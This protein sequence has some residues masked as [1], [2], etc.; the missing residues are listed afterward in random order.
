M[1]LGK[2]NV[3]I[4]IQIKNVQKITELKNSLKALRKE[5]RDIE[6]AT[7]EGSKSQGISS[8][9][10]NENA[11]A[12]DNQSKSLRELNRKQKA[13]IKS[14]GS[15]AK[16]MIKGAA[17]IGI[18][19]GAFRVIVRTVG[20]FVSTFT[21]FEFVMAKVRAVSG[22]TTK[23]FQELTASAEELGRTTFFTATQVGELQLAYSKL[24]FT[25]REINQ[26]SEATIDLATATGT[27]LQRASQVA[28]ASIRGFGLDASETQRVVDVM[29]VSFASS[30]MDIEK[31]STSMTKVAPIAQSAGFSIE[32][33]ASIMSKLT[34]SG[35]EASIAGTSLRNI[36]LKMQDP[37]SKLSQ[38]FG[39]TIHSLDD[40][41]PAMKKF[42]SEGGSM[43]EV[44]E[45]VDIR[46][47]GAFETMLM[48]T[49]TILEYRDSLEAAT[50]EGERMAAM[51]G[52]TLQGSFLKVK[53]AAQ[54]VSISLMKNFSGALK[55]NMV[56][57]SAWLN[58]L[59]QSPSKLADVIFWVKATVRAILSVVVGLKVMRIATVANIAVQKAFSLAIGNSA[60]AL[61]T[62]KKA[63]L[64]FSL[65][66]KTLR[67][68]IISTGIGALVVVLGELAAGF[69]MAQSKE[70]KMAAV[71]NEY[72]QVISEMGNH[73]QALIDIE[74]GADAATEDRIGL[75]GALIEKF[76]DLNT[77]DKERE[78]ILAQ[79]YKLDSEHFADL[80]IGE[81]NLNDL[82]KAR[83]LY[84]AAIEKE[85]E[86]KIKVQQYKKANKEIEG[87]EREAL[88]IRANMEKNNNE[89]IYHRRIKSE[90]EWHQ[91]TSMMFKNR[92]INT[93][94]RWNA[95]HTLELEVI[96]KALKGSNK[97]IENTK[98]AYESRNDV[99]IAEGEAQGK[100]DE[101]EKNMQS[102]ILNIKRRRKEGQTGAEWAR[103][104]A[105]AT[106]RATKSQLHQQFNSLGETEKNGTKGINMLIKIQDIELQ[107][108]IAHLNELKELNSKAETESFS[109]LTAR[110]L[111]REKL[112]D[113]GI[114]GN[115]IS[116]YNRKEELLII[117]NETL[118]NTYDLMG[119]EEKASNIGLQNRLKFKKN[120][121]A[122][123]VLWNEAIKMED[124]SDYKEQQHLLN[125]SLERKEISSSEH[126]EKMIDLSDEYLEKKLLAVQGD[127]KKEMKIY[128]EQDKNNLKRIKLTNKK[129]LEIQKDA[130]KTKNLN[131]ELERASSNMSDIEFMN[132]KLDLEQEALNAK[133]IL[134]KDDAD[135]M[136]D[137][138]NEQL[139][140]DVKVFE[141]Q[142]DM[143]QQAIS[144]MG[145]VGSALTSLAGDNEKL[146][147]V[148]EIGNA[149]T[150]VSNALTT[151]QTL[152]TNLNTLASAKSDGVNIL[153]NITKKAGLFLTKKKIL[154]ETTE[155]GI[156]IADTT[157]TTLGTAAQIANT[158]ATG[159]DTAVTGAGL[160]VKATD[161][162]LSSA[163]GL[164][165][166]GIVAM[167]AMAAMV[168]KVMKMFEHGGV[169]EG[170]GKFANGGMVHGPSHANGGVKFA[171]GGRVNEL[172][173]G[174][175]VINKRSTA[176]FRNQL[177]SMNQ[178]GGGVKFADG[179]LMSSPAFS[180]AQFNANNQNQMMGAMSGQRKVVVVESDIT[181]SQATVNV[182]QANA[183]F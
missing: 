104:E 23:E 69:M 178:A 5:Q 30:A 64:A 143:R 49:D 137:I 141:T 61:G 102:R 48:S 125:V 146:N 88:A 134:Y 98:E 139:A 12:V 59:A 71:T 133:A 81:T 107:L 89:L 144:A 70:E 122:L 13:A 46:Q 129:K 176:M 47:A 109:D 74:E 135:M 43:A 99:I 101:W 1:A 18:L 110:L 91:T 157:A 36:L 31:W 120:E 175:A 148:K 28:G 32:D 62:A 27:D 171:V 86:D 16:S 53:S 4:D 66:L 182:I 72:G 40:L 94:K 136:R 177:S 166:F 56:R 73:R 108:E 152:R 38:S 161:T 42:V 138:K 82:T 173:G 183:T 11:K 3:A 21:E 132:K 159:A 85:E 113:E 41:V 97:I 26:A 90:L 127:E 2:S 24:G 20:G 45:V 106:A 67:S 92:T 142:E 95:Q 158:T 140:H 167:I 130:E 33:T 78:G 179:G 60:V 83:K 117:K 80:K 180:E 162:I 93:L 9:R 34:D 68:A 111:A 17:A 54:G 126:R 37:T 44:M 181:N 22:A 8:K 6:K 174:E 154:A 153:S 35:I 76:E 75:V 163:K 147:A 57:L 15:M 165:P 77:T 114:E 150:M 170:R 96:N 29:A 58:T 25:A 160:A 128:A 63:S 172:E 103:Q 116:E 115:I 131:L 39:G 55:D 168:M 145:G 10:Y 155:T 156:K 100:L 50:G 124:E 151:I 14:N 87:N 19:V 112:R 119:E 169:I 84:E 65:G 51:V 118:D 123:L 7:K 149:I 105:E 121:L 52:D 164:G 79:L